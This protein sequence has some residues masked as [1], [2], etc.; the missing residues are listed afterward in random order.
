MTW[1]ACWG[2]PSGPV[3]R[4]GAQG[5]GLFVPGMVVY[6][7]KRGRFPAMSITGGQCALQCAHCRGNLLQ[8][9]A[10]VSTPESL[11]QR[12]RGA[13]ARG[14][15]GIL[16]SGGCAKDGRLPWEAFAEALAGIKRQTGLFVAVH[17]GFVDAGPGQ[18][19]G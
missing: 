15:A 16:I 8:G 18:S 13:Q 5:L 7:G 1:A 6:E 11:L 19:L 12:A 2:W 10:D 17:S 9:M 14:D 4:N 3:P